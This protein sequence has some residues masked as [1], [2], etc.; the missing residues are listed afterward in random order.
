[1]TGTVL[2]GRKYRAYPEYK[3]S[4]VEWLEKLPSD[5][6]TMKVKFLLKDGS[7]GIKI[8]PFGSALK[9]EDMVKK[10]IRVYGQ[11]NV[12][13]RDFT[14]GKR[15]ISEKKYS[16]MKV[17]TAD[18]GDI[19]IT[20]MGTSGKCQVV[21]TD[22]D[23]GIIDS[24]LLKIRTNKRI[25]PELF[26]LL[27]DEAQE[28]KDQIGKQGKGSIMHGLNSTIVKDLEFPLPSVSEQR[29][30]LYFLDHETAKIDTLIA[31]NSRFSHRSH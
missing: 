8:G 27:V 31:S 15:F 3:D 23:L 6:Q 29:Q 28:V 13:K 21:P 2:S 1:M 22:A 25:L 12:I 9:L 26:R 18:V 30:I 24:H 7:E 10:G 20:M 19:L 17:Y 16:E 5:W 14:L 4:G 11:E